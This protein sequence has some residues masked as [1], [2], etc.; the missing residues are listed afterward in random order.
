MRQNSLRVL[1]MF[2]FSLKAAEKSRRRAAAGA[3][4]TGALAVV[5]PSN[6]APLEL[7]MANEKKHRYSHS[8]RA[9][10]VL[11]TTRGSCGSASTVC[12]A[13]CSDPGWAANTVGE[14]TRGS[15]MLHL[16]REWN[17]GLFVFLLNK[18]IIIILISKLLLETVT[19]S[20]AF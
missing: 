4:C 10:K 20:E 1:A 16:S 14:F 2:G 18:I 19:G 15:I 12:C 7:M 5:Q 8:P 6:W 9:K 17:Q 11:S 13:C 3:F